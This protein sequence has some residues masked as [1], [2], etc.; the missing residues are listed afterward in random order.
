MSM[1]PKK[2]KKIIAK[3]DK[4][5][6]LFKSNKEI[7]AES[8]GK[9]LIVTETNN[10]TITDKTPIIIDKLWLNNITN[11]RK[12][13]SKLIRSYYSGGMDID[14]CRTTLYMIQTLLQAFKIEGE[15]SYMAR[16]EALEK[17]LKKAEK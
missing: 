14:K 1:Y 6:P 2:T 9:E 4:N 7:V 12:T 16:I 3:N 5:S 10:K 17:A 8:E 13:I 15:L 11:A